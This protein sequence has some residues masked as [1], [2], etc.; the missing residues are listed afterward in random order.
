[1]QN[2]KDFYTAELIGSIKPASF[3]E[4]EKM[5]LSKAN[6]LSQAS[7]L[8]PNGVDFKK[9][10]DLLPV[11]FNLAVI[12]KFNQNGEGIGTLSAAR[13]LKQFVHKPLNIEHMKDKIVGHIVNASFSD[14]QPDFEENDVSDFLERKD[15]FYITIAAFIYKH[16]YP[17]LAE[18]LI[19]AADP[20]SEIYQAYSSSWEIAFDEFDIAIG[21]DELQSCSVINKENESFADYMQKLKRFNG[22]GNCKEGKVNLLIKGENIYPVG[23]ALTMNPAANVSG[24]YTLSSIIQESKEDEEEDEDMEEDTKSY[25][26]NEKNITNSNKKEE[27]SSNSQNVCVKIK[28]FKE[29][30][31]MTDEQFKKLESLI[32][33]AISGGETKES[34]ASVTKQFAEALKEAGTE[35]KSKAEIAEQ[36]QKETESQLNETKASLDSVNE[37]LTKIKNDLAVQ[38]A[39]SLFNSRVK[40]VEDSFELSEAELKIVVDEVKGLDSNEKSFEDYLAKASVIFA[41]KNKATKADREE[42]R[43]LAIEE[44]AKKLLESSASVKEGEKEEKKEGDEENKEIEV[45]E[46][47]K[48]SIPNGSQSEKETLFERI[49]KTG[50][51]VEKE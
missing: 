27:L 35:W 6:L 11:V 46:E 41:D 24:I 15:P 21:E 17:E 48:A 10:I 28:K 16:I 12:N 29:Y 26:N 43:K 25:A 5:G 40:A 19:K 13:V 14:K 9:N 34:A 44:A 39:A 4:L 32:E 1:M 50:L 49:R 2:L 47:S 31:S 37:E 36:K 20:S 22:S 30:F 38:A 7:S 45:K 42:Q 51:S 23:A 8:I 3:E 18:Y 33:G